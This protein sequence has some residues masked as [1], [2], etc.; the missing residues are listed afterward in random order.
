VVDG[1]GQVILRTT[2]ET[3]PAAIRAARRHSCNKP[4][5]RRLRR[6]GHEAGALSPWLQPQ[7][8]AL[9]LPVVCLE[10]THVRSALNARRN[11]TDAAEALDIAHRVRTGWYQSAYIKSEACY[12]LR[13]LLTPR[14]NLKR[15]FL[16]LE[17]GVRPVNMCRN[18]MP[19]CWK[20]TLGSASG[21]KVTRYGLTNRLPDS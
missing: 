20:V 5:L 17:H 1:D 12:R 8:L 4:F 10:A 21:N 15:K 14:R 16:D 13:L 19:G 7:L 6:V 3:E 18:L 11:K 2:A 9:G